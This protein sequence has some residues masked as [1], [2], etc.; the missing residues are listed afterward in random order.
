MQYLYSLIIQFLDQ[1]LIE[2]F[3]HQFF[4]FFLNISLEVQCFFVLS[5][6]IEDFADVHHLVIA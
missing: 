5:P 2:Q 3:E 1:K 6:N 4:L